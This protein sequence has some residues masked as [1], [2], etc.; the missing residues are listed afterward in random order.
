MSPWVKLSDGFPDDPA[1]GNVDP[2]LR[3]LAI[4]LHVTALCYSGRALTDGGVARSQVRRLVD[5]SAYDVDP[6]DVAEA[7]VAVGRWSE[8]DGGYQIVGYLDEQPSREKVLRDRADWRSRQA[9]SRESRRDTDGDTPRDTPRESSRPVPVP[10]PVP[11]PQG[12]KTSPC[13]RTATQE[14]VPS[15]VIGY[16][17]SKAGREPTAADKRSLQT[18]CKR[19]DPGLVTLA[20]GQAVVQGESVDN[21]ALITTIAKAEATTAGEEA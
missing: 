21:F 1:L 8:A 18:L 10:V 19:Y 16:W 11:D 12:Q 15:D 6:L 5:F 2:V 13:R 4:E 3:A 9:K 17:T 20:I 14:Q 7:L